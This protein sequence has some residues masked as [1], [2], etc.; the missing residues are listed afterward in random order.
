MY[1]DGGIRRGTDVL[2]ALALGARAA[3]AARA[4][5]CALAVDGEAG[6]AHALSL[7]SDEIALGLGLLGCTSPEQ[8]TRAHVEPALPY[9][10]PAERLPRADVRTQLLLPDGRRPAAQ[11]RKSATIRLGDKSGKYK[12]GMVVQVLCGVRFS[13][14]EYVFD[15]VI[16]KVEVKTLG[17]LSPREI[18]H[19][20][21]EIRR[22]DEM[23][24]FLG[25]LY[26]REVGRGRPRH[27]HPL[28]ADP[29][30]A[31]RARLR[32]RS[33]L[34]LG[35]GESRFDCTNSIS[36][37]TSLRI[38]VRSSRASGEIFFFA[39]IVL[40]EKL[41]QKLVEL[42]FDSHQRQHDSPAIFRAEIVVRHCAMVT[43][44]TVARKTLLRTCSSGGA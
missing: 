43:T 44:E 35:R 28:L 30:R 3:F 14:R 42:L 2:K 8:V 27:R 25:Q 24:T 37:R 32:Q 19:D 23:A 38:S 29:E 34:A 7:L 13:A 18:E 15:A 36:A 31:G 1:V 26:N 21:P 5:A 16:D 17:E 39:I 11:G 6:V 10:F 22:T 12:K 4:F 9:D 40:S 41:V 20:N 33:V